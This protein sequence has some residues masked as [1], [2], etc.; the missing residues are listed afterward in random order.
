MD[1]WAKLYSD[2]NFLCVC[3]VGSKQAQQ[4]AIQFGSELKL[5]SCVNGFIDNR[6]DMPIYGQLGCSGFI[7]LDK[8]HQVISKCTSSF[9]SVRDLAF[10]HVQ[11][12]IAS[13]Q[14]GF[15]VPKICPGEFGRLVGLTSKQSLNGEMC[16]CVGADAGV[17]GRLH[18]VLMGQQSKQQKPMRVK[19]Q[20]LIKVNDQG[21]I[22]DDNDG[23]YSDHETQVTNS[24]EGDCKSGG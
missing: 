4:L 13:V 17:D 22:V 15:G 1:E 23:G 7:L 14:A 9:M 12:V 11:A 6:N 2:V 3:V 10:K 16:I 18:V 5:T 19:P 20:N 8:T 24:D 21:Q